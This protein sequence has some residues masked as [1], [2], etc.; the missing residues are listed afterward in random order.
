[1]DDHAFEI[2]IEHCAWARRVGQT[3]RELMAAIGAP[4]LAYPNWADAERAVERAWLT[5]NYPKKVNPDA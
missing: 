3:P 2:A 5:I 4:W 1:M